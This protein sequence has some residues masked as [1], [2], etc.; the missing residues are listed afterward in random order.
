[1]QLCV[2]EHAHPRPD[3]NV[4]ILDALRGLSEAATGTPHDDVVRSGLVEALMRSK[5]YMAASR[6]AAAAPPGATHTADGLLR[7]LAHARRA[8]A[9]ESLAHRRLDPATAQ[10]SPRTLDA[11]VRCLAM[12][13]PHLDAGRVNALIDAAGPLATTDLWGRLAMGHATHGRVS[14]VS[15]VLI[16]IERAHGRNKLGGLAHGAEIRVH[17]I[18]LMKG[19]AVMA[20]RRMRGCGVAST[21]EHLADL[22]RCHGALGELKGAVGFFYKNENVAGFKTSLDMRA[23][24]AEA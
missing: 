8:A 16:D 2:D 14:S 11:A 12:S 7:G 9:V 17:A 5:S 21:P 19:D 6:T 22:V 23:A 24:L 4:N 3:S 20:F 1:M 13:K 10:P 18:R 15:K